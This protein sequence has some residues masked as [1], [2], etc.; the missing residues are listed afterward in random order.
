MRYGVIITG[1][2]PAEQVELARTAEAAGWD[3][4]FTWDGI[5][6]GD[7]VHVFDPFAILA[8]FALATERVTLGAIVHPFSRRRPW[9]LARQTTTVDRLSNGR[10]V[11][12]V[13][14]GARDDSGFGPVG[15]T[16]GRPAQAAKLDEV[17]TALQ[18]LWSGEPYAHAGTHFAFPAMAFAPTPVQRP[19]IPVWVVGLWNRPRSMV[20]AL[21]WDGILPSVGNGDLTAEVVAEVRAWIGERRSLDGYEIVVEGVTAGD[22]LAAARAHLRPF[23]EAGATWWVESNWSTWAVDDQR[24]RIEAGPPAER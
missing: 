18:G 16:E 13:G 17:L 4:V 11:L 20:R 21:R 2:E 5:H 23:E 24:R 9:E 1:G 12:P 7:D 19:R 8:A 22:D 3:G 6:V 15:E 10:L 14:L